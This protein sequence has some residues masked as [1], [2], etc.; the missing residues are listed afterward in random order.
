MATFLAERSL[1][2]N[3]IEFVNLIVDHL[4]EHGVGQLPRL[5]I[6]R[7]RP[8]ALM[9][10]RLQISRLAARMGCHSHDHRL[11]DAELDELMRSL[12]AVRANAVAA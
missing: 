5:Q 11:T 7:P 10:P 3:Q 9:S 2:A 1:S 12:E 8:G 6:S 4:T